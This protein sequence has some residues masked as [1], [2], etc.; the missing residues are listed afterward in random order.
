MIMD[1]TTLSISDPTQ[2]PIAGLKVC[3]LNNRGEPM[4]FKSE[5]EVDT[6]FAPSSY[7]KNDSNKQNLDVNC[8]EAYLKFFTDFDTWAVEYITLNSLRLLGEELPLE[9]VSELYKPCVK[10]T[11]SYEPKLRTKITTQ[12][13]NKTRYWTMDKGA[14]LEPGCWETTVF[15]TRVRMPYMYT[16]A[17]SIGFTLDCTDVQVCKEF[18]PTACPF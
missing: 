15:R 4:W 1:T 11:A 18:S 5:D 9:K 14:R 12:G 8:S 2:T 17:S 3:K 16:T 10:R 7:E 13:L 6:P